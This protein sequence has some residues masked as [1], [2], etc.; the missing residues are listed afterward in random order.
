MTIDGRSHPSTREHKRRLA[1]AQLRSNNRFL[2]SLTEDQ[3]AEAERLWGETEL[4]AEA[5]ALRLGTTKGVVVGYAHRRGWGQRGGP[6]VPTFDQRIDA[7]H[8]EMDRVLRICADPLLLRAEMRQNRSVV[9]RPGMPPA[10][11]AALAKYDPAR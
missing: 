1:V 7:L 11:R 4:S 10:L 6:S 9:T 2:P 5:I 3:I 8:A